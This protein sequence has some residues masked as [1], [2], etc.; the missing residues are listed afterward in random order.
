MFTLFTFY[1]SDEWK[2]LLATLKQ[3]RT[4]ADGFIIC[5]HCGRPILKPYDLIGHHIEELTE[6]NVNDYTISLNPENIAFVHHGCHNRIHDRFE[7]RTQRQVFIVY[8]APLSG[9]TTFVKEN[10]I[11]GDLIV[12]LESIWESISGSKYAK[13]NRL[14]AIAFKVRDA[15][16]DAVKHRLGQWRN[17]YIIGGYPLQSERERLA[18]E[19]HARLIYIDTPKE[20]CLERLENDTERPKED[21]KKYIAEYFDRAGHP[22][23]KNF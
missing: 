18:Q 15:E 12:D 10:A 3:E 11:E 8:G 20:V 14:K 16:L 1:R 13:P 22:P 9:K 2:K 7:K 21:Y 5:E 4:N 19:M 6:E 23:Q 17:A